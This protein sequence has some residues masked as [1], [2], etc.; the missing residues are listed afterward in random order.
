MGSFKNDFSIILNVFNCLHWLIF[1]NIGN[2]QKNW[3]TFMFYFWVKIIKN[4]QRPTRGK[5]FIGFLW[6]ITI[7]SLIFIDID[8]KL[9]CDKNETNS[10]VCA[11]M[12][13]SMQVCV[14]V[15]GY[16]QVWVGVRG[17]VRVYMCAWGHARICAGM[18]GCVRVHAGVCGINFQNTYWRIES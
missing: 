11:G 5:F 17:C 18:S 14:A 8:D 4:F 16:M 1:W 9:K 6:F 10:G 15:H 7:N 13:R 3:H 12:C 2:I